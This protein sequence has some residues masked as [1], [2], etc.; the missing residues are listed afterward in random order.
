MSRPKIL[1]N[2]GGKFSFLFCLYWLKIHRDL[3][4][5]ESIW[6]LYLKTILNF[7]L[8]FLK[9]FFEKDQVSK[10]YFPFFYSNLCKLAC[11]GENHKC[12][13]F[14]KDCILKTKFER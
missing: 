10:Y 3:K 5:F 12:V 11:K 2:F 9:N 6:K 13:L 1:S 7:P 4:L 14:S 8:F